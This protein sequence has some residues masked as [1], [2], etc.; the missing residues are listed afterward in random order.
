M[1]EGT[2]EI[3]SGDHAVKLVAGDS[4]AYPAD[5]DHAIVNVGPDRAVTYLIDT[6][7]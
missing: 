7:P 3:E 4:V 1:R 5:I 6:V 2:V